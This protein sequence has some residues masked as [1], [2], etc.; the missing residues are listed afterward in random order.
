LSLRNF[1]EL[2]V[3]P[4]VSL[5]SIVSGVP[6]A[7]IHWRKDTNFTDKEILCIHWLSPVWSCAFLGWK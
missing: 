7:A 3:L 5:Y 1:S 6:E 2:N 4:M